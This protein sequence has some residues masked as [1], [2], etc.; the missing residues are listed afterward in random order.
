MHST[1]HYGR[2]ED[3]YRSGLHEFLEAF[4]RH[5]NR[6]GMEIQHTY[7]NSP[8]IDEEAKLNEGQSQT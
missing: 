5:N 6:L 8:S 3:I 7:L 1:L 4:L 2:I